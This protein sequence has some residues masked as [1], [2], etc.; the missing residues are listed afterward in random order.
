MHLSYYIGHG[1]LNKLNTI[2]YIYSTAAAPHL[3]ISNIQEGVLIP[4]K[5]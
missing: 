3:W 2:V 5:W 1:I 4:M